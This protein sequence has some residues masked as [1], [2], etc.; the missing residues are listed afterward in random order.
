MRRSRTSRRGAGVAIMERESF[1][2]F[3]LLLV[4]GLKEGLKTKL[5]ENG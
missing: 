3:V 2:F 5:V 4:L 1:S